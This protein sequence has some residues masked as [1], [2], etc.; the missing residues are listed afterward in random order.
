M[1]EY[2]QRCIYYYE[3]TLKAMGLYINDSVC[4]PVDNSTITYT[5]PIE[6]REKY[7]NISEHY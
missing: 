2:V 1:I 5:H 6:Y 4:Y 3:E 7:A